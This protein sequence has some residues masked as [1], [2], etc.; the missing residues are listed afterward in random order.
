MLILLQS[1]A[2]PQNLSLYNAIQFALKNNKTIMYSSEENYLSAG[3]QL[4]LEYAIYNPSLNAQASFSQSL[5]KTQTFMPLTGYE[6]SQ[7]NRYRQIIPDLSL[8]QTFLTPLGSTLTL[9][10]GVQT[11]ASGVSSFSFQTNPTLGLSYQQPLS[12]QGIASGHIDKELAEETYRQSGLSYELQKEQLVISVI[13]SYFQLWQAEQSVEQSKRDKESAER[14]LKIADLKLN[15]G[16]IAEFEELNLRV[17][18]NLAED[19]LLQAQN[20]L[21]TQTIS[22][23]QL[24]GAN[25]DSTVTLEQNIKIDSINFTL[26]EATQRA[27]NNRLE[28]KQSEISLAGDSLSLTQTSS[29]LSPVL[30]LNASYNFNSNLEPYFFQSF[31]MPNYGWNILGTISI[32]IYDGGRTSY[33]TEI[34]ER[35]IA[36]QKENLSLL[37]QDIAIDIETQYR[38]LMLDVKRFKSLSFSLKAAS[39]ALNIAE[40]RFNSGQISSTEIE[41]VRDRYNAAKNAL[42]GAKIS[43]IIERANLAKA[44]G[45]L[46]KWIESMKE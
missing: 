8:Q 10:G 35:N 11:L 18:Y 19:N 9:S 4:N 20:A 25:I 13:Q 30:Q 40:L 39:E 5:T 46:F 23:M 16:S 45:E 41:N 43:Y 28:I 2:F 26:Q 37:K 36:I 38:T 6:L 21:K 29:S 14:I 31:D 12:L 7:Y 42:D 33:R 44:T 32:P 24:L 1:R 27:M 22:F 3:A 34:S 17:Q 15:Q